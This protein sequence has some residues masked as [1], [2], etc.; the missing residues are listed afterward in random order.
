M[1]TR[2]DLKSTGHKYGDWIVDKAVTCSE[3]GEEY[4]ECSEC[5]NKKTQ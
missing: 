3:D 5:H 4:R 1:I 2:T